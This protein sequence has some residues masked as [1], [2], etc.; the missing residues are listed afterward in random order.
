M[1]S[2]G[3]AIDRIVVVN[4]PQKNNTRPLHPVFKQ[5]R[6]TQKCKSFLLYNIAA[7]QLFVALF[8]L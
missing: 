4:W 1:A 2:I 6:L 8:W 5:K 3:L 7:K